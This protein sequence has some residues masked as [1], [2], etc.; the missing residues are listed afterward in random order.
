M[1]ITE[2]RTDVVS[3]TEYSAGIV[4]ALGTVGGG[5]VEGEVQEPQLAPN[6]MLYFTLTD[7]EALLRCKVFSRDAQRLEHA[8]GHG[9]LVQVR[10]DRPDYFAR[11]GSLSVIVSELRLAGEG[12]L[13]R[14]RAELLELLTSQG[15]CN[16]SAW[17][18]PLK[19]PRAVGVISGADS[20]GMGD[21]VAALTHRFPPVH[22]ITCTARVQGAGAP[23]DII[24]A[25]ALLDAHPLVDVI[26]I[27]RGGGSVQDL[28]AFDHEGLCRAVRACDTPVIAAIGHTNNVPVCN[29][30][31]WSTET[32]SRSPEL[33]VP[34]ASALRRELELAGA[35]L[36]PVP[37]RLRALADKVASS[38]VDAAGQLR[39]RELDV[40]RA[41]AD[42]QSAEHD[43]FRAREAGLARGR[44]VL[45][46]VPARLPDVADIATL[47]G[48]LDTRALTFFSGRAESI[49]ALADFSAAVRARLETQTQTVRDAA[50][51]LDAV[52]GRLDAQTQAVELAAPP[53]GAVVAALDARQERVSERGTLLASGIRKELGDHLYNYGRAIARL[54]GE[55]HAG[56][57]ARL[58]R[59]H[60]RASETGARLDA[61]CR[62]RLA[63]AV[64]GLDHV[65]QLL[66]ASDPR[67]RGWVLPTGSDGSV[68]RAVSALSIGERLSLSF[69]DGTAGAVIESIPNQE[70]P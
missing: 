68:I 10:I 50:A 28:V 40:A 8:P 32:P 58:E 43:F 46:G 69:H 25:L 31:T 67:R 18:V 39:A 37:E 20:K 27:A 65:T 54:T 38:E 49:R 11:R 7:G 34:D 33:A 16:T 59:A 26:I 6:G 44:E 36:A 15:L 51:G 22:I 9:D 63:D 17:K 4:R 55:V 35:H 66:N 57:L 12:E 52:A 70:S 61:D 29:H 23:G 14:R 3:V 5:I 21:V 48:R 2:P 56:A 60:E 41:A 42:L 45:A 19:F 64:R 13:L 47:A 62:R 24:D 1:S 53:A 30:V